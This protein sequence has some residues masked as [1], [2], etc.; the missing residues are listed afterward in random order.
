MARALDNGHK[1]LDADYWCVRLAAAIGGA[2]HVPPALARAEL[3]RAL[4]EFT[5][6]RI[7]SADV[8][9]MIREHTKGEVR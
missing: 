7:V 2:L 4:K 8:R 6:A 1:P 3:E 5:E 9:R